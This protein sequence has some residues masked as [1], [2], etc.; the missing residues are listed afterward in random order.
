MRLT[1]SALQRGVNAGVFMVP[2]LALWLPSGYSWGAAWLLVLA[3]LGCRQWWGKPVTRSTWWLC[4]TI[5]FMA[6]LLCLDFFP[7]NS[8]KPLDKP[9]KYL[10]VLPVLFLLVHVV[11][12]ARWLWRGLAVGA[13]GAGGIALLQTAVR[14]MARAGG[15]TNEIQFGNLALA[16][17]LMCLVGLAALWHQWRPTERLA[18]AGGV[19]MGLTASVLSQSRGGWLAFGLLLPVL[20][21]LWVRWLP[22]RRV[23]R[24]GGVLLLVA[25]I[26]GGS[27]H[28]TLQSR[29]GQVWQEAQTFSTTGFAANSIGQRLAH[30]QLAWQLG[31]EKPVLGWGTAGYDQEKWARAER[32]EVAIYVTQ[33]SHAHNELLDTFARRGVVGVLALLA[34]YAVPLAIFWPSR[35][36]ALRCKSG[37]VRDDDLAL[38]MLGVTLVLS[39]VGFGLTQVFFAHNSGNMF[40]LFMVA[41]LN[42]LLA[43]PKRAQA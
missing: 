26:V 37:A 24:M 31:I 27:F 4:G 28:Q 33:F 18:L 8:L 36:R 9:A 10:A 39:Y 1:E 6:L 40:Y 3:L 41:I 13:W 32:G 20:V 38:R 19:L 16:L 22:W 34:L 7:A 5:T 15:H 17:G 30:W 35:R 2:G 29:F 21:W 42:G 43:E 23:L 25:L 11:P 12:N 14:H